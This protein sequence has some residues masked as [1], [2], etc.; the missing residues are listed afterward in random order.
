MD[1]TSAFSPYKNLDGYNFISNFHQKC[2]GGGVAFYIK[3]TTE[4]TLCDELT[5]MKKNFFES[6][7]INIRNKNDTIK[8]GTIYRS[9][10]NDSESNIKFRSHLDECLKNIKSCRKCFI[11][12]DFTYDLVKTIPNSHYPTSLK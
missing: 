9:P 11:F 7:F 10:L 6:I 4:F 8:C 3:D 1:K 12:G 2:I 5:I